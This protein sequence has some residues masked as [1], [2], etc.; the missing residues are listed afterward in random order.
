MG[1][2]EVKKAF[3]SFFKDKDIGVDELLSLLNGIPA[4]EI[5]ECLNSILN[6]YTELSIKT[7]NILEEGI[8]ALGAIALKAETAEER[9]MFAN[10]IAK[11]C[12]SAREESREDRKVIT[13]V[14]MILGGVALCGVAI[15]VA[16][17]NPDK[18]KELGRAAFNMIAD[19][20]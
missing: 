15:V 19:K 17:K 3:V 20:A 1:K 10:E 16:F 8:K 2:E 12:E 5:I 4:K 13:R 18:A 11:L 14:A 9:A 7:K 6:S